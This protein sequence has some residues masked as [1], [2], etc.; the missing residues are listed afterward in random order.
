MPGALHRLERG[1][2]RRLKQ[3]GV[4]STLDAARSRVNV[5]AAIYST[6]FC[7]S[8]GTRL[9]KDLRCHLMA[10]DCNVLL[11]LT[12]LINLINLLKN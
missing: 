5:R 9:S 8:V 7:S 12:S 10:R 4:G 6:L 11:S 3:T 1:L 2:L